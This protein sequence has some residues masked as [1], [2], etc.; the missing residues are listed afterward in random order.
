MRC[1]SGGRLWRLSI[2][3]RLATLIWKPRRPKGLLPVTRII[4]PK[5]RAPGTCG[6]GIVVGVG[7]L[8][9]GLALF[10]A[11]QESISAVGR[12]PLVLVYSL[13]SC[14]THR[15]ARFLLTMASQR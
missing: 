3:N 7:V 8:H 12:P 14:Q 15:G 2:L 11:P 6:I 4:I 10:Q 5:L 9:L 13:V 1:A